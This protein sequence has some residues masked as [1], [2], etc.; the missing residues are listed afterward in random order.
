MLPK[1]LELSHHRHTTLSQ[2]QGTYS[3]HPDCRSTPNCV[4]LS[5]NIDQTSANNMWT[6]E[7]YTRLSMSTGVRYVYPTLS[8]VCYARTDNRSATNFMR[9]SKNMAQISASNMW[10]LEVFTRLTVFM[11]VHY[12]GLRPPPPYRQLHSSTAHK[13]RSLSRQYNYTKLCESL[14]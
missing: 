6:F 9:H 3:T 4:K 1:S 13:F 8:D 5:R 12:V 14:E 11:G 2:Q 10:T 7:V